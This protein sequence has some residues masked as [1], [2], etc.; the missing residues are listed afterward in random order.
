MYKNNEYLKTTNILCI[1]YMTRKLLFI[2]GILEK[3]FMSF[4]AVHFLY[5][6]CHFPEENY[7]TLILLFT[8]LTDINTHK[9]D[10]KR[11]CNKVTQNKARKI[12]CNNS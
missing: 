8:L 4:Y 11:E 3:I 6:F 5:M 9:S 1:I 2:Y 12:S 10:Y 7:F